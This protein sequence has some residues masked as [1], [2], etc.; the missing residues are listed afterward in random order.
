MHT[1][2]AKKTE[3]VS[4]VSA[5]HPGGEKLIDLVKAFTRPLRGRPDHLILDSFDHEYFL[6]FNFEPDNENPKAL[7]T[8]DI[9]LVPLLAEDYLAESYR[10]VA[11]AN[12]H[13]IMRL[14]A[15]LGVERFSDK[16]KE[17]YYANNNSLRHTSV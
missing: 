15:A 3:A 13:G 2:R 10:L 7:G 14:L 8:C 12:K 5:V 16:V 6:I 11:D 9:E 4:I 17:F 1:D